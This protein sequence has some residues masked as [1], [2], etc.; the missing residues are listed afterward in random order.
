V[1][2]LFA[3][4][5]GETEFEYNQQLNYTANL[6]VAATGPSNTDTTVVMAKG[7]D[8]ELT[9]M[10]PDLVQYK[11]KFKELRLQK[12]TYIVRDNRLNADIDAIEVAFGPLGATDPSD[13]EAVLVATIDAIPAG[14]DAAGDAE[15]HHENTRSAAPL[16]FDLDFGIAQGTEF[17]VQAGDQAPQ[18]GITLDVEI[19][20]TLI[21][22]PI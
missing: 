14:S 18:G 15:I 7:V 5:C 20:L 10:T 13:P 8:F 2:G 1:L 9:T 17:Q 16:V 11:G 19:F 4:A 21:A 3:T 12:V 22:D 6:Q